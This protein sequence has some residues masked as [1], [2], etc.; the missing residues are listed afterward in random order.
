MKAI[1]E[2]KFN[3]EAWIKLILRSI[4]AL[5]DP[6]HQAHLLKYNSLIHIDC[7]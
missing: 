5:P 1:L 2:I 4:L 6:V 3:I 7:T